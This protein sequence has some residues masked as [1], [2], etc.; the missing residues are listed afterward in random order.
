MMKVTPTINQSQIN[1]RH[2]FINH[3]VKNRCPNVNGDGKLAIHN[4]TYILVISKCMLNV[5]RPSFEVVKE[6]RILLAEKMSWKYSSTY[7]NDIRRV[8][9]RSVL[10]ANA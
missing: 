3:G 9:M 7:K 4:W 10:A 2:L 1:L 5:I 6:G 8:Q